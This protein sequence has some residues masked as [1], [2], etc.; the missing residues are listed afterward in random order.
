[1][2]LHI[3]K[4]GP[5]PLRGA[6]K[7]KGRQITAV[8]SGFE[9]KGFSALAFFVKNAAILIQLKKGYAARQPLGEW[10]IPHIK[11]D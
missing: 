4:G 6:V 3:I 1:M 5:P 2:F 7:V 11:I 9:K 8:P 10:L